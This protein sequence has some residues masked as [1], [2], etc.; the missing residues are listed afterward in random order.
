M[1]LRVIVP[2]EPFMT[3]ADIPGSH[4]P[5]DEVVVAM[6]AAVVA[7]FDGPDG[8][9]RRCLGPQTLELSLAGLRFCGDELPCPPLIPDSVVVKYLDADGAPQTMATGVYGVYGNI[10]RVKRGGVLPAIGCYPYPV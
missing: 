9:L 4:S 7:Q 10:V 1:S 6:I 3:P 8:T 2:P 5:T